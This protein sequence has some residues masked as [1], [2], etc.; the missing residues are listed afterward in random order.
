MIQVD[1]SRFE[2]MSGHGNSEEYRP[3]TASYS[4]NNMQFCPEPSENY[5]PSCWQA[6]EIIKMRCLE[7][8]VSIAICD[9]RASL[10]RQMYVE[11]NLSGHFAVKGG[12]TRRMARFRTM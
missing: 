9:Q 8:N 11:G 7:N 5:L 2:I 6:G 4:K 10:A 1:K 3:W 12:N